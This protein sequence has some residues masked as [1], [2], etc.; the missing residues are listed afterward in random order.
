VSGDLERA[1]RPDR[2]RQAFSIAILRVLASAT[3]G[4]R[5]RSTPWPKL[6]R[7]SRHMKMPI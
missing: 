5:I 3:F 2:V 4:M 1:R 6:A 7:M